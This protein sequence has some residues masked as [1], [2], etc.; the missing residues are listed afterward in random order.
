MTIN[1]IWRRIQEHAGEEFRT[2]TGLS[3]AYEVNGGHVRSSRTNWNIARSDFEKVID[4]MPVKSVTD[5]SNLVRGSS[6][7]LAILRDPRIG[8]EGG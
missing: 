3:F 5:I 6:Y 2:V 7:I 4:R 1:A 8:T